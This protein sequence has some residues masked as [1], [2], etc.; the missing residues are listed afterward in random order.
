MS[1][2][3]PEQRVYTTIPDVGDD[4]ALAA[5]ERNNPEELR[6]VVV[7]VA[8][9]GTDPI[10]AEKYCLKL[11]RH[12]HYVTRGNAILGF[13]H[14][15]RRFRELNEA[16]VKPLIENA[17]IDESEY[18]RGQAWATVDDVTHFLGW[19]IATPS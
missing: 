6:L 15:A 2:E 7:G 3:I 8:L 11:A 16:L 9:Y 4:E 1:E 17:L 18:V 14:L 12:N 10:F 19:K 5:L 13:G